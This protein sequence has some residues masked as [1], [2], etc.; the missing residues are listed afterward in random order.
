M[1]D[2]DF[3]DASG[4]LIDEVQFAR[5][6][7]IGYT[8]QVLVAQVPV[9]IDDVEE[10]EDGV[11]SITIV[12]MFNRFRALGV[13]ELQEHHFS[14]FMAH[15]DIYEL[16]LINPSASPSCDTT[17]PPVKKRRS[18]DLEAKHDAYSDPTVAAIAELTNGGIKTRGGF[19]PKIVSNK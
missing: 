5:V 7:C 10:V 17:E 19:H 3:F 6:V 15:G 16:L 18:S 8:E 4:F 9:R 1:E 2:L 13:P 12:P 11:Y 14:V